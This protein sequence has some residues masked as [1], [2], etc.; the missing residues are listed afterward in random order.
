MSQTKITR[1]T[2]MEVNLGNFNHN[3]EQIRKIIKPNTTIMP[4]MKANAYGTY[5][6]T[7]PEIVNQF[8]IIG[9]ATVDEGITLREL[10]FQKEIFILNQPTNSE[11]DKIIEN[12][13]IIG[14]SAKEFLTEIQKQKKQVKVH[15]EIETGMG[16]TGIAFQDIQKWLEEIE[17]TPNLKVEGIYTHLSVPDTDKTYTKQQLETFQKAVEL[18]KTK[19]NKIKYIHALASNGIVNFPEAQYNLVRPG[20]LLY[21]YSS[22]EKI[23]EKLKLKPVTTLKSKITFL[24]EVEKQTSI[25]Y[26][27]TFI[28]KRKSKIATIPIG[29][30][31]GIPRSL[32]NK[33]EVVIKGK[34]VPIVGMVCMD[35]IMVDVTDS[36][37]VNMGDEV[38]IWDNDQITLDDIAHHCDTINY[39]MISTIS[40]RV[41]RKFKNE[42]GSGN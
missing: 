26:A 24:K 17:K 33:G 15:L 39:E 32:S 10:G 6:N 35:S 30:A 28:T 22:Q 19:I 18:I 20:L 2:V 29:Y 12:D 27:R 25:S 7:K 14:L 42:K 16:R 21:G 1:P 13:L 37:E 8:Q 23:A 3:L 4:I 36:K 38:F 31:D 41:P 34:K 11:L 5:L 9:V 40:T